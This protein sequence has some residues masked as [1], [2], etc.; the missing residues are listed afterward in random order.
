M[1]SSFSFIWLSPLSG[2]H[3]PGGLRSVVAESLLVKHQLRILNRG[4]KR[5]PN[6]RVTERIIAGL[7]TLFMKP[8]RVLR[9]AIVLKPSTLL[10]LHHVLAKRKYRMLF[11]RKRWRPPGPKGPNKELIEA[12]VEL[13]RRNL[14]WGCPRSTDNDPLY[15]FHQ[16][17]ANLRVLEVTEI[18]T[19]PYVPLS[20]PFVE[21]LIRTLR[22]ECGPHVILDRRRPGGQAT[23]FPTLL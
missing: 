23:R 8:A 21:R 1:C 11:S 12:V 18:R 22:R 16:W 15:R 6:L 4:R 19:V 7:C 3:G 5:A 17:L 10:H 13:K 9:S 2:L 20:H 14:N